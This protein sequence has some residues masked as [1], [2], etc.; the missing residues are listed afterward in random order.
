MEGDTEASISDIATSTATSDP[1]GVDYEAVIS[2]LS[3][4]DQPTPEVRLEAM[5]HAEIFCWIL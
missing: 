2:N 3:A 1:T 4:E 5:W